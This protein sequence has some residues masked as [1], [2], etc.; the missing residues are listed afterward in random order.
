[1]KTK[2]IILI[3]FILSMIALIFSGCDGGSPVIPSIP[4]NGEISNYFQLDVPY[5][6][7]NS[8]NTCL[9]A[10]AA[11]VL[12]Y[13]EDPRDIVEIR[14]KLALPWQEDGTGGIMYSGHGDVDKLFDYVKS[15]GFNTKKE[16]D[17]LTIEEIKDKLEDGFPIIVL[18]D[19]NLDANKKQDGHFSVIVGYREIGESDEEN[20]L[21]INDPWYDPQ[22][23]RG[24]YW[25]V[26]YSNF[27]IRNSNW[28]KEN[29]NLISDLSHSYII[30][31]DTSITPETYTITASAGSHGSISPSGDITV[32]QGSDKLFTI[33]PDIGYQIYDVLVDGS[34][35]GAVS[36]YTF[37]NVSEDHTI[38]ATFISVPPGIVHNLTK[39]TYYNT[40]QAALDDADNDNTIEVA[41]G[42]YDETIT[43]PFIKKII[44][45]S[46]NGA[47]ST[48]IRGNDDSAT[49]VSDSPREGTTLEGFTITH[50]SGYKGRGIYTNGN[51]TIK[52]CIISGNT[53][54][55]YF[56]DG[57][58]IYNYD[59][60][61]TII[62]TT[63]SGNTAGDHFSDGGG[64]GNDYGS[65]NIIGST[66]SGNTT[67]ES[68]GGIHNYKGSIAITGSTI[69]GN[70]SYWQS[71]GGIYSYYGTITII[72][73]IISG[74][75]ADYGNGG[76][77][78]NYC[79]SL[80]IT[81][82]TISGNS[83]DY[84]GGGIYNYKGS[85]TITGSTISSNSTND[86]GGGIYLYS[87]SDITIG[88]SSDAEK[89]IICGNYKS[90][91]VLSLDQQIMD[92]S[93]SLYETYEDT[94]HISVY[95]D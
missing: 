40:I 28:W 7:Q 86:N 27:K 36:S 56:S 52:N 13:Y 43:F 24:Q 87:S 23:P 26:T 16:W 5:I 2:K 84:D 60:T 77:I 57:G 4:D 15:L 1:M 95:C 8:N 21:I 46:I 9:P 49:V 25:E 62:G 44:L 10:S 81:G 30:W 79:G 92:N 71:G 91:E 93:G 42:T 55:D 72:G 12:K 3:I 94:N 61:I 74:N 41:D 38:F 32:N 59:G 50:I 69:S 85:L 89:N 29:H 70:T 20:K 45:R 19:F 65:I 78:E 33:T 63:I 68:G 31:K 83:A 39:D 67:N 88:G 51:L 6:E 80:A 66:I 53:A 34:S 64:I 17:G 35:E 18:Q 22:S 14:D 11:M 90:G 37:T 75:T 82:S 48:I 73:T 76:G 54:G 47:S 58:G